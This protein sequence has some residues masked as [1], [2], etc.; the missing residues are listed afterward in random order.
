MKS[1]FSPNMKKVI[2][3]IWRKKEVVL[4]KDFKL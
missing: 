4:M 1:N 2:Q 3:E